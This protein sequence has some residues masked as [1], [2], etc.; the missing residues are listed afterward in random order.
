MAKQTEPVERDGDSRVAANTE[1][2][3]QAATDL[4]EAGKPYTVTP[5]AKG[6]RFTLHPGRRIE[7]WHMSARDI[8]HPRQC[9]G[10]DELIANVGDGVIVLR[11][12]TATDRHGDGT[13][14]VSKQM[15]AKA[16]ACDQFTHVHPGGDLLTSKRK[17]VL[18]D[19]DGE[20][21]SFDDKPAPRARR[22]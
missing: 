13:P 7:N 19:A 15:Q 3:I 20:F 12:G 2:A 10:N 1:Q 8:S 18:V 14:G 21:V 22:R 11:N 6:W 5:H 4:L 9:N 16:A 17:A